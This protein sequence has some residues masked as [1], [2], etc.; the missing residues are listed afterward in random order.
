MAEDI[1]HYGAIRLRVQGSG[2]LIPSFLSL[3]DRNVQ[4]LPVIGMGSGPGREPTRL[5]NFTQQR[6][7]LRLKTT[8]IN[9]VM[10]INRIIVYV[11]PLWTNFPS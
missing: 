7:R 8:G 1:L 2:N 6:A 9:E 10:K 3:D 11:K 5:S 4:V